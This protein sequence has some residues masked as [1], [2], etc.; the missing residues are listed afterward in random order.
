[1]LVCL[2]IHLLTGYY[3]NSFYFH[4]D[5]CFGPGHEEG[6]TINGRDGS[7]VTGKLNKM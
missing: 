6:W 1:M 2:I 5:E 4:D 7:S 3:F